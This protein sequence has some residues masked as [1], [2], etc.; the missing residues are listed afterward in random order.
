MEQPTW[1]TFD[2]PPPDH[3]FLIVVFWWPEGEAYNMCLHT[4]TNRW[5]SGVMEAD[6][7]GKGTL[8]VRWMFRPDYP[9]LPETNG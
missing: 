5:D 4:W 3:S 9:E 8:P 6:G 2:T 1:N 7:W